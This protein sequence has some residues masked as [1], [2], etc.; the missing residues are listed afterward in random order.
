M[1]ECIN[2]APDLVLIVSRGKREMS[3]ATPA[4]PPD[5]RETRK[6]GFP[7]V[8]AGPGLASNWSEPTIRCP[9]S[10]TSISEIIIVL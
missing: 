2:E 5:A 8:R 9:V 3:T 6:L 7:L 1:I 10:I 4:A